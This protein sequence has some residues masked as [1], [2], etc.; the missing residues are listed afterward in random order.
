MKSNVLLFVLG[1][2]GDNIVSEKGQRYVASCW[3]TAQYLHIAVSL[4]A[5]SI[6]MKL[7]DCISQAYLPFFA[8]MPQGQGGGVVRDSL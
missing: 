5:A 8:A 6:L 1:D 4:L 7:S 3:F 2:Y